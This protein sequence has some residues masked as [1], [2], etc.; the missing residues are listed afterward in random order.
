MVGDVS[1]VGNFESQIL[2]IDLAK[3]EVAWTLDDP[4]RDFPFYASAAVTEQVAVL[5]GRDKTVYAFHPKTGEIQWTHT[6]GGRIDSSPV[7]AGK[8]VFIATQ[9][10]QLLALNL[11]TGS[12]VWNF[13][14]GESMTASPSVAAG[15]LIIGTV[16][17]TLFAFAEPV[18]KL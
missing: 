5:G 12:V 1:V 18:R 6:T 9:G 4:E 17:G 14:T 2:G 15:Y 16:D 3:A 7:I 11:E 10:G 8:R 13:D